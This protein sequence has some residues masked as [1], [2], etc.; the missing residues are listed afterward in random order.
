MNGMKRAVCLAGLAVVST[1]CGGGRHLD[2][3]Y[4]TLHNTMA[5]MG[6]VQSGAIHQGEIGEGTETEVTFDMR[7]GE[8]YTLVAI[9]SNGVDDLDVIVR[10]A[11][12][13]EL[14]RDVTVDQEAATQFC[15][16][17]GSH[18][19][20]VRADRGSGRFL[21]ST[22]SG[23]R[24]GPMPRPRGGEPSPPVQVA[25]GPGSCA[26]PFD[27]ALGSPARGDTTGAASLMA[28][29]CISTGTAPEHVYRFQL[30]ERSLFNAVLN[31]SYDGA[32]YLLGVCGESRSELACN[33]DSPSTA[34]SEVSAT[35]EAGTY[36]LVVD[37]FG[38]NSG[39]YEVTATASPMQTLTQVCAAATVLTPGQSIAGTTAGSADYF[40]A[41]CAGSHSPDRVYALDVAQP[42]RVR[43]RMQSTHDGA[44]YLQ[45][46]C[47]NPAS[48]IECNDDFGDTQHSLVTAEVA[49]GRYYVFADGYGQGSVGDYSI[50]AD[51]GPTGGG[52]APGDNCSA[53]A[54]VTLGQ[55]WSADSFAAADDLAGSCGGQG[56]PD[57]VHQFTVS[58]RSRVRAQLRDQEYPALMYLQSSCGGAELACAGAGAELDLTLAPGTYFLVVDGEAAGAF[59][60]AEVD[61]RVDDLTA[62]ERACRSAPM[63]RPGRQ[64][65]GSTASS[66]DR[67]QSTC[68]DRSQSPDLVYRL[69]LSRRQHVRI[70]AEQADFDGAI[71]VRS[72]CTSGSAEVACNDDAGDNRHSMIEVTL[73]AGLYYVYVDGYATGNAGAFTLDVELSAP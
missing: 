66:S 55:P 35:L 33:D 17:S 16:S 3:R 31:S 59:G 8:C 72:D 69:R 64:I 42:S 9:G 19:V 45:S 50:T 34:R 30:E 51:L 43:V 71:Y 68:A 5:A 62:L 46:E 60:N 37:G 29:S 70:S 24:S 61:L 10:D 47:G 20:F 28:G 41:S 40:Q 7:P 11:E 27:L 38:G 58:S 57:T 49:P 26:E 39:D 2:A 63:I 23:G 25:G 6:L 65:S 36:F 48:E 22:W 13:V 21:I 52:S 44:L 4:V 73:D 32:L 53:P 14:A 1:S 67:F 54:S 18:S 12:G 56:A 15:P